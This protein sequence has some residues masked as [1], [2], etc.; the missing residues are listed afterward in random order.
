MELFTAVLLGIVLSAVCGMRIFVPPL[1][2]SIGAQLDWIP[3][4]E[5]FAWLAAPE[6]TLVLGIAT[7]LEVGAYY[8]PWLDNLLDALATPLAVIAGTVV[9]ASQFF[10]IPLIADQSP[11]VGWVLAAIGGGGTAAIIQLLTV[12][13]RAVSTGV[14][15]GFG[16]FIVA[17]FE[18]IAALFFSLLAILVP[19]VAT[20]LLLALAIMLAVLIQRNYLRLRRGR[21]PASNSATT[22]TA[23]PD[24]DDG[25]AAGKGAEH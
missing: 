22:V 1:F 15:G 10:D 25:E 18:A 9:A 14:T 20:T 2:L 16:N 13:V 5:S 3:L 19:F 17:T 21:Q 12:A 4:A 11:T 23:T 8:I 24:P 6:A 7:L